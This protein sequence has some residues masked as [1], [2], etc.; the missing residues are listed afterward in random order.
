MLKGKYV[1]LWEDGKTPLDRVEQFCRERQ[2]TNFADCMSAMSREY[3]LL[4][5]WALRGYHSCS[6]VRG[7][8]GR[9]SKIRKEISN[10]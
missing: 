2:I 8:Q 5:E 9:L 7:I 10:I 3:P 6:R 1:S 4:F